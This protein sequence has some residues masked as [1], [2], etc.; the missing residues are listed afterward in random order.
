[1][2]RLDEPVAQLVEQPTLNRLVEGSSPS[3]L[4]LRVADSVT[5][6]AS[7]V[8]GAADS[9]NHNVPH[10]KNHVRQT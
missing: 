6:F 5:E 8:L 4:A 1:M 3:G 10:Q 2:C 7:P 9:S